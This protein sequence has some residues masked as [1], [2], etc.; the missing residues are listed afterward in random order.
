MSFCCADLS[1]INER[2]SGE[3]SLA[4]NVE[5]ILSIVALFLIVGGLLSWNWKSRLA[6][7]SPN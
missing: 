4:L 1:A 2:S 5:L 6:I 3:E 7:K